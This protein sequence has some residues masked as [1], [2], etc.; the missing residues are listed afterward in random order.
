M[1]IGKKKDQQEFEFRRKK[2]RELGV[3]ARPR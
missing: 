3:K 1:V 2:G